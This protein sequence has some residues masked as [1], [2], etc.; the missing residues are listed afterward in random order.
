ML[1]QISGVTSGEPEKA[2]KQGVLHCSQVHGRQ[3]SAHAALHEATQVDKKA[4][5][6]A[7]GLLFMTLL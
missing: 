7:R 5:S 6:G 2:L 1:Q 4:N 3:V